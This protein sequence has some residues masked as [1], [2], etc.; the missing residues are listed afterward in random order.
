V[1]GCCVGNITMTDM[2]KA[3]GIPQKRAD[4]LN[5]KCFG[6]IAQLQEDGEMNQIDK[7]IKCI[8]GF[9][10]TGKEVFYLGLIFGRI[11]QIEATAQDGAEKY[12]EHHWRELAKAREK[13]SEHPEFG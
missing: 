9:G 7:A 11:I 4:V 8:S 12:V 13:L 3:L 5:D 2:A 1:R 10:K 6:T